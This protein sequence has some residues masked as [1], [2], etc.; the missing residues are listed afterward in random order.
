[1]TPKCSDCSKDLKRIREYQE[2]FYKCLGCKAE[3]TKEDIEDDEDGS[4]Y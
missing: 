4:D 3:F 1:M 2:V